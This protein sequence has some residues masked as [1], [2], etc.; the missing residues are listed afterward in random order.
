MTNPNAPVKVPRPDPALETKLPP[1]KSYYIKSWKDGATQEQNEAM[2]KL[3]AEDLSGKIDVP[4]FRDEWVP[5]GDN[6]NGP[7]AWVETWVIDSPLLCLRTDVTVWEVWPETDEDGNVTVEGVLEPGWFA[8]FR[9]REGDQD[10]EELAEPALAL[11]V[12]LRQPTNPQLEWAGEE[13]ATPVV[14]AEEGEV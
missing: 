5:E 2:A 14:P 9:L 4:F 8:N 6:P 11:G 7:G 3:A 13:R 12:T 10:V 1:W